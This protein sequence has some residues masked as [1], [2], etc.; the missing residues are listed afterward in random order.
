MNVEVDVFSADH[1]WKTSISAFIWKPE[2]AIAV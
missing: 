2:A 1:G